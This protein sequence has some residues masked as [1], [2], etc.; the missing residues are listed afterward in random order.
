MIL[1]Y[2]IHRLNR[3]SKLQVTYTRKELHV[4]E[5]RGGGSDS[6][7]IKLV[8]DD[9]E[10]DELADAIMDIKRQALLGIEDDAK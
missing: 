10:L 2:P 6:F 3:Q 7:G 1:T 8:L 9:N 5:F 4:V